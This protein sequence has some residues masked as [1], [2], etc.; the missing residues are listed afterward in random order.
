M[1]LG[2]FLHVKCT[3]LVEWSVT[4]VWRFFLVT[5]AL[6]FLLMTD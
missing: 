4:K 1:L 6:T 3:P 5:L 2:I